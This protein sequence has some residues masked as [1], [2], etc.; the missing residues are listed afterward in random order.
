MSPNN[1]KQ[2]E[3]LLYLTEGIIDTIVVNTSLRFT[4]I[5]SSG[6]LFTE[7]AQ[8]KALFVAQGAQD[9]DGKPA[10]VVCL[11]MNNADKECVCFSLEDAMA[12]HCSAELLLL[13]KTSRCCVRVWVEE[14]GFDGPQ[15][16]AVSKL[17]FI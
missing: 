11:S 16:F 9:K 7:G 8:N 3:P 2:K 12:T 15:P 4:L 17:M 13:A 5:P 1:R 6:F 10:R 14:K